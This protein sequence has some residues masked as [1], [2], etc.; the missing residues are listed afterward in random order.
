MIPDLLYTSLL[1]I[2][3]SE[4]EAKVYLELMS[5]KTRSV[6][7]IC[8]THD[9]NRVKAYKVLETLKNNGL[10]FKENDFSG[11]IEVETPAK[12][13]SMLRAREKQAKNLVTNLTESLPDILNHFYDENRK[14]YTRVFQGQIQ[15]RILFD[16]ILDE[17]KI[18]DE[19]LNL[20]EGEDFY[21]LMRPIYF[22]DWIKRRI[23]K[24]VF[25]RVIATNDNKFITKE[26]EVDSQSLRKCRILNDQVDLKPGCISILKHKVIIW[27][28]KL[29]E[30]VV[31]D[32]DSISSFYKS[33]FESIWSL[34]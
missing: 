7:K 21:T 31:I 18:G 19:L 32:S 24:E 10:I 28:T 5:S 9:I 20:S 11:K 23:K 6:T 34:L 1:E 27:D 2:G 12:V 14:P 29:V 8:Q 22:K 15:L 17:S 16:E 33:L 13:I 30:A 4:L 26:M 25:A 3:L